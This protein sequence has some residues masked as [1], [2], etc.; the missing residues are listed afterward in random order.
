MARKTTRVAGVKLRRGKV[1]S[2]G[3]SWRLVAPGGKRAFKASLLKNLN[4][5]GE[6]LAIFRVLP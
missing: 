6:R 3:K 4:V 1:L 2:R 5:R